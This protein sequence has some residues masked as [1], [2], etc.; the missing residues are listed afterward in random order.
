MIIKKIK[1]KSL[2]QRLLCAGLSV[3]LSAALMAAASSAAAETL[4]VRLDFSRFNQ[5]ILQT[6]LTGKNYY[7]F[8]AVDADT[9]IMHFQEFILKEKFPEFRGY[10]T[11]PET[12]LAYTD[13]DGLLYDGVRDVVG[14]IADRP[15]VTT[16]VLYIWE[17]MRYLQWKQGGRAVLDSDAFSY[18]FLPGNVHPDAA[19]A[20]PPQ[21]DVPFGGLIGTDMVLNEVYLNRETVFFSVRKGDMSM[22]F[23]QSIEN[24]P[25]AGLRLVLTVLQQESGLRLHYNQKAL[26]RLRE[27]GFREVCLVIGDQEQVYSL[28]QL[29]GN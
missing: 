27:L 5:A 22:L 11:S 8:Q 20:P 13:A 6:P 16:V 2:L 14:R 7:D 12:V 4:T 26:D 19:T 1:T 29:Q 18:S 9:S 24:S 25:G 23:T 10:G 3:L 17:G 28:E 15:D 21:N